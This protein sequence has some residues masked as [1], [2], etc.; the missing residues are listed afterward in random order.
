MAGTPLDPL[1]WSKNG[2][3]LVTTREGMAYALT[4]SGAVR[5]AAKLREPLSTGPVPLRSGLW[6]AGSSQGSV[7]TLEG[8]RPSRARLANS[9][10]LS[11]VP[12]ADSFVG[13]SAEGLFWPGGSLAQTAVRLGCGPDAVLVV[14]PDGALGWLKENAV[15]WFGASPEPISAAPACSRDGRVF[16]PLASGALLVVD[17]SGESRRQELGRAALFTPLVDEARAQ[18]VVSAAS[19][20]SVALPLGAL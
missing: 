8:W 11:L 15:H 6:A 9:A 13:L 2:E 18:L 10:V 19:G 4:T 16:V 5:T 3:L 7:F 1:R 17:P 14:A 12:H 20:Q